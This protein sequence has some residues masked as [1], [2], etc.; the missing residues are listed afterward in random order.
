MLFENVVGQD[1]LTRFDRPKRGNNRKKNK[2]RRKPLK[3]ANKN[4]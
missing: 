1:S 3:P 4:A 2:K